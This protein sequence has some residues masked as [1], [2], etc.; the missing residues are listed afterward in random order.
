MT[1]VLTV[2]FAVLAAVSN[3][4]ATVLQRKAAREVPQDDAF[5]F[6]LMI[7]LMHNPVWL[8]GIA[9]IICAAVCQALA[10]T[11]GSLAL[12]QPIFVAELPFALLIACAVFHRRLPAYGWGAV[13]MVAVGLALFLAAAAPS[14]T[15][16]SVDLAVWALTLI[17]AGGAATLCVLAALR[18][19][20]G[21]ARAALFATAAA[22]GYAL[23][24][25]LMKS[26]ATAFD[27]HGAVAF[28]TSW[29]TYAF[30]ATGAGALF[31]L[32][33][34]MQAGPLVASQPALTLGDAT[35]S[36]CMG[37]LVFGEHVRTGWWLLPQAIG[38]LLVVAGTTVLPHVRYAE[39]AAPTTEDRPV[40][41]AA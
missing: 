12:V 4:L 37:L 30:A 15:H 21:R 41:D 29:Q 16:P 26:A 39:E 18:R 9:A 6:R 13:A 5:R 38:V 10:L 36:L 33:N 20:N 2:L 19:P 25:A 35:V 22:I 3:A 28:F 1:A 34:A 11:L 23:T 40:R 31:L 32:S 14:G 27:R 8:G 7:A 17:A 24:A